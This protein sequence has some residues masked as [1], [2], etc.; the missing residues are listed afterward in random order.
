M[1][2]SRASH[3]LLLA[4]IVAV[5]GCAL[6]P[7]YERPGVTEPETYRQPVKSGES[8]ANLGWWQQFQ[9]PQM[10][11]L[12]EL[13]L[14]ENND[15]AIAVSRIEEARARYGFVRADQFPRVDGTAGAGRGNLINQFIPGV[16]A[17]DQYVLAGE[18]S[19]EVDLFGKLRRSTEAARAELLATEEARRAVT[20]TLIAE[21]A[22][23]YLL[24]RDLDTRYEISQRTLKTRKDSTALVTARFDKGTVALI[25][26]NQAQIEEADA[27]VQMASLER[28]VIQ[29]ENLI[30]V[31]VGRNPEPILRQRNA[32]LRL[33][34]PDVPA[35]LPSEL[36]ERRPDVRQAEQ[37]LSA[38][39]ARIGI[40]E[41]LRWPSLNLT[42]SLGLASNDLS[43]LL[44]SDAKIWDISG[45]LFAPIFN[46][47]Q[48][49]RRV[50][51]E[52]ART[53]QLLN[54]YEQTV[55]QAFREVEDALVGIRTL[56]NEARAREGQVKAA[57]SAAT[58][59]RARYDGGV[60]SYLEVLESERSLFR[61]E[62]A[63]SSVRREQLVGVVSLY[64][65]LGGGWT[66]DA[67]SGA[68]ASLS[69]V[70]SGP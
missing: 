57:R 18:V 68:N 40:A 61:A 26:V 14:T 5:G 56:H 31:L 3:S 34:P 69:G 48:N 52:K 21:V 41:A 23:A 55:L 53:E 62:L 47:G 15:L 35:G 44:D 10:R 32:K 46:S 30:N 17:Q 66:Q 45:N 12:I 19:W 25:D 11:A 9:D 59:S 50:E 28:A 16:G 67:E 6:G 33:S 38:Q 39:T 13:A 22:S 65:A 49:K 29:T 54:A 42:A 1:F 43:D 60:T 8:I 7:D 27:A 36:L 24:L 64:K 58:L 20:I 2:V 51:V 4:A 70:Q 37:Q 63:E